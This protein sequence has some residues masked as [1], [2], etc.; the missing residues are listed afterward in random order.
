M[1]NIFLDIDAGTIDWSRAQFALTAIYHWLF[2]PLTLGL[3]L[4]MGIMETRYYRTKDAF[5]K[6]CA[7]FWQRL[8]GINFAMGVATGLILEFEF[9]TNWSNYSWFVGDIFGAPLAIEGIVA[10]FMESTFVAVMFFGWK[11]VSAGFHLA[12]TWLTGL[13][14][15]I[16]AWWILVANAWMQYPVGCE[17]NPDTMRNEMTS[18]WDVALSPFAV[19]KFFHTVISAWII[20]AVFVVAVS[21][22]YL[23][24]K[25]HTRLAVESMKVGAVVGLIAAFGAAFTGHHSAY[26]VAKVQPMKLAAMEALYN[27]GTDQSLTIISAVNPFKQADYENE[28]EPALKI[29]MPNMLSFLATNDFHG[30]VPGINDILN[31]YTKPDGTVELSADEKIARGKLAIQ[32]L[33]D[34]RQAKLD[35]RAD[36]AAAHLKV[37]RENMPYF[38][39]G[40]IRDKSELVPSVPINFY[41]F[42]LMVGLGC[43]F[44]LFFIGMVLLSFKIPFFSIVTRRLLAAVGLLKETKAD[45]HGPTKMPSWLFKG[46]ILMVPLAY[47]ASESGWLVAE[48]G[49]QPWTIQDM[50]PTW[51]AVSDL[52][53][54]SVALTFFI[55]LFLFTTM[56]AVELRIMYKQ[57]KKGP[58]DLSD[59]PDN[60]QTSH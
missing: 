46:A 8:F 57:I 7:K 28:E 30:Y 27:G 1:Q 54:S 26:Q 22:W 60:P 34:Y 32:A 41:A 5:W 58:N 35:D 14:A 19:D 49:R 6:E 59:T 23:L 55:F 43:L 17:F 21:S 42:R 33:Q 39:Y 56:L 11:K 9:G 29:A 3:A 31:G 53:S 40:Y 15:T 25:R 36:D 51:A 44:I 18:F 20:G 37:L 2:V 52:H 24:K 4:I 38:G 48:F 45:V 12:S 47:I 10:F 13:G 50:L 16:S